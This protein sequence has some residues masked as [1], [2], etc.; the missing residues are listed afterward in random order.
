MKNKVM[1]LDEIC[2]LIQIDTYGQP[3]V[4][5]PTDGASVVIYNSFFK[6]VNSN[7]TFSLKEIECVSSECCFNNNVI[8]I[9]QKLKE[10]IQNSQE[11]IYIYL[12]NNISYK[13]ELTSSV[14]KIS[15]HGVCLDNCYVRSFSGDVTFSSVW[16]K[17]LKVTKKKGDLRL[18]Y[19]SGDLINISNQ[20]GYTQIRH[21]LNERIYVKTMFGDIDTHLLPK[22]CDY[23]ILVRTNGNQGVDP[24]CVSDE[25]SKILCLDSGYGNV[26]VLRGK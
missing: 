26:K 20:D 22:S 1:K 12:N 9:G 17:R 2:R 23:R 7:Y 16:A 13:L 14:G 8:D 15:V 24:Y 25:R 11:P 10:R 3:I 6:C 5:K 21:S 19:M 18:S 4:I